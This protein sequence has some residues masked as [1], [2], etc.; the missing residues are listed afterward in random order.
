MEGDRGNPFY[1]LHRYK[2]TDGACA[3]DGTLKSARVH[4]SGKLAAVCIMERC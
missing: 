4:I 1:L 2:V 3:R